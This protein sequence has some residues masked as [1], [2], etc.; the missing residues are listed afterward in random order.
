MLF[1]SGITVEERP[2][3]MRQ[4][5]QI[6][7]THGVLFKNSAISIQTTEED[8]GHVADRLIHTIQAVGFFIYHRSHR[9]QPTF[10]DEVE[11]VLM[12]S[13]IVYI[14]HHT[15]KGHGRSNKVDFYV[16]SGRNIILEALTASTV[17][18]A[19]NKIDVVTLKH[20]DLR[21]A[22]IPHRFLLAI[23]DREPETA[24]HWNDEMIKGELDAYFQGSAIWWSREQP[25]LIEILKTSSA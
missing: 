22:D 13:R 2:E 24:R 16:N 6:A 23:D 9:S 1:V 10:R 7:A 15:I 11:E 25:R 19:R 12:N 3:L 5:Q 21:N 14:P 17:S 18:S 4:A 20:L 8:I